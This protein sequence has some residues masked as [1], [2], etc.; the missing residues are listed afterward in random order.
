[1][2]KKPKIRD[3]PNSIIEKSLN[4]AGILLELGGVSAPEK[5]NELAKSTLKSGKALK[6]FREIVNAQGGNPDVTADDIILGRYTHN[7]L[8][9]KEG[10]IEAI[11]NKAI[12]KIAR[13]A[14]AP[15]DKG[16][17]VMLSLKKGERAEKGDIL[18]TIFSENKRKLKNKLKKT[19]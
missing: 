5:G 19:Y 11:R 16:A 12:I 17:G 1:M 18:F 7:I 8:A 13:A 4:L 9:S 2:L 6:K 14:G 10:Y 15:K 3:K